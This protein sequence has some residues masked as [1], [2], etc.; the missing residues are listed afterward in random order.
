VAKRKS[1]PTK[2]NN[3]EPLFTSW[4]DEAGKTKA[5]S[6]AAKA[7]S[8]VGAIQHSSGSSIFKDIAP[9]ISVRDDFSRNDY[10]YFRPSEAIPTKPKDI[11][12]DC[13][14]A[15]DRIGLIHNVIDMMADF[16]CQGI[17]LV[18]PNK[19][20]EEFHQ[21]WDF[22]V[23]LKD[24][25]ERFSNLLYR[26]ANVPVYRLT[27]KLNS[28]KAKDLQRGIAA[29][30]I[31]IKDPPSLD[32]AEIPWQ[33]IILNPLL[34]DPINEQI[35]Q[36]AGEMRYQINLPVKLL[37]KLKN[38]KG[39]FEQAFVSSLPPF[40]LD[41][42]NKGERTV[43]LDPEKFNMYHYK[44]DDWQ[45]WAHPMTYA[46]LDDIKMLEKMKMAD[47][48][49]LDGAI[50]HIRLWNLG[51]LEHK[52]A[53]TPAGIQRLADVLMSSRGG[54]TI[55]I[56]WGPELQLKESGMDGSKWLGEEKYRP[57]LNNIYAGIG[58]PPT[59]T[60]SA[61]QSGFT[62]NFISLKTL[63][64]RLQYGRN[65]LIQMWKRE[66]K[67]VQRARGFRFPAELVF[68][69]MVLSDE[70]AEKALLIQL[71][72]RDLIS[73]ESIQYRFGEIPELEQIRIN[74]ERRARE[75][76]IM[77][78]KAS[79]WHNPEKDFEKEKI[80]LQSG[81]ATP[82]EVGLDL[83]PRKAG[84]V[85]LAERKLTTKESVSKNKGVPQQGRPKNSKDNKKR[86]QRRVLPRSKADFISKLATARIM[87]GKIADIVNNAYLRSVGKK[88]VRSLT[89]DECDG[90]ENLKFAVLSNITLG[91]T[92][93]EELVGGLV[94]KPLNVP[95][96]ITELY[97]YSLQKWMAVHGEQPTIDSL[98]DMQATAYV[99][100]NEADN[101]DISV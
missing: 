63:I 66:L 2:T 61:T 101:S 75:R 68:D 46:I 34:I 33:Y 24:R 20:I 27:A 9:N 50:S 98:R 6:E 45:V 86:K 23:G 96:P 17:R 22:K 10:E 38:P 41:A 57:V 8:D 80:S 81:Q 92:V 3:T 19:R 94:S 28:R 58:I 29:P 39:D 85:P 40:M 99:L 31:E 97:N 4:T 53:P 25:S 84:E 55:D 44:K 48:A 5:L 87:Q 93:T 70:A 32:R 67:L 69:R 74:R 35:G 56:M 90:L 77:A 7:M 30:D 43:P 26:G 15:Y 60:G 11:M 42:I 64:E 49:A 88:N 62:N 83:K 65:I 76:N 82:S 89:T 36:F 78:P 14:L 37:N 52:I 18:H 21:E 79:P 12:R 16:T 1:L 71:A 73:V 72:D 95:E 13:M 91:E 59:L 100:H 47:I 54:G 51:S